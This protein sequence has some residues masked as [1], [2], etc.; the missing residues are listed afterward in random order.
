MKDVYYMF[1]I[2]ILTW[3]LTICI[4][5]GHTQNDKY[6]YN[7]E[8]VLILQTQ[9]AKSVD[10][11]KQFKFRSDNIILLADEASNVT[12]QTKKDLLE[13]RTRGWHTF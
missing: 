2:V 3:S 12:E 13:C 9:L 5:I 11:M 7:S 10:L 4:I 8:Y 1:L 6:M